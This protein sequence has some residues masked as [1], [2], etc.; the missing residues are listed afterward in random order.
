ME[1]RDLSE[2]E[3]FHSDNRGLHH[4]QRPTEQKE[5]MFLQEVLAFEEEPVD[6]TEE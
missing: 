2:R 5:K 1:M 6:E 3:S 4:H